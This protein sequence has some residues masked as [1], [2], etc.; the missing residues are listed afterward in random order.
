MV[1]DPPALPELLFPPLPAPQQLA[2]A[3]SGRF[4]GA[5][6]EAPEASAVPQPLQLQL[7]YQQSE[8]SYAAAV[9]GSLQAGD[10]CRLQPQ[11]EGCRLPGLDGAPLG[12]SGPGPAPLQLLAAA[13][14]AKRAAAGEWQAACA[15]LGD[16]FRCS[17][18]T[19]FAI[20]QGAPCGGE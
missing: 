2:L 4:A 9:L 12:A 15:D 1:E 11:E 7:P 3:P 14:R 20:E 10:P 13:E 16:A 19:G 8:E 5:G 6:A 17:P 18:F